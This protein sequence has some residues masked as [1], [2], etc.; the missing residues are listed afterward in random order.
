M[1][2]QHSQNT[3]FFLSGWGVVW[4]RGKRQSFVP[5]EAN[6]LQPEHLS[7]SSQLWAAACAKGHHGTAPWDP[8]SSS[9]ALSVANSPWGWSPVFTTAQVPQ[10]LPLTSL[11]D[12]DIYVKYHTSQGQGVGERGFLIPQAILKWPHSF[13]TLCSL[14]TLLALPSA[15]T[16]GP[17]LPH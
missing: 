14:E 4:E 11:S 13:K 3:I 9:P 6:T 1:K 5:W 8:T 17:S 15:S 12:G 2:T 10:R 7:C 16:P